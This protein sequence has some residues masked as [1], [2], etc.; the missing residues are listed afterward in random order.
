[1]KAEGFKGGV[2]T[3]EVQALCQD[4]IY[5]FVAVCIVSVLS[6]SSALPQK[7]E[8]VQIS[9]TVFLC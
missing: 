1:M 2:N 5:S 4:K 6:Y 7:Q 3:S 8:D 9:E